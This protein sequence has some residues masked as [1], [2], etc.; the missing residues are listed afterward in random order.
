MRIIFLAAA[1]LALSLSPGGFAATFDGSQPIICATFEMLE[2]EPGLRCEQQT[3][4]NLDAPQ[5]LQISVQDKTIAGTRPSGASINAKIEIVRHTEGQMFLQG[6]D[7]TRGWS[8]AINEAKG[9]MSLAIHDDAS[10]YVIFGA[11]TPR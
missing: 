2:C 7:K 3:A 11:C 5:F 8:M 9:N 1:A 4:D 6:I 10:S